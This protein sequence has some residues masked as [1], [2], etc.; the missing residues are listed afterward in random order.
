M[1][2]RGCRE[3]ITHIVI[4]QW[5]GDK[6][7]G[8]FRINLKLERRSLMSASTIAKASS[9]SAYTTSVF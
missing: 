5:P 1:L 7:G 2:I 4:P 8:C 3:H 9:T 6:G